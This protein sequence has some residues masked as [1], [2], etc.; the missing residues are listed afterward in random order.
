[1]KVKI[2]IGNGIPTNLR[3][4]TTVWYVKEFYL[5][6]APDSPLDQANR[7]KLNQITL[8]ELAW[9]DF[10]SVMELYDLFYGKAGIFQVN[11]KPV[12]IAVGQ[13]FCS[14]ITLAHS[15][16]IQETV[17]KKVQG[18]YTGEPAKTYFLGL[19]WLRYWFDWA[20]ENTRCPAICKVKIH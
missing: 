2:T 20:I 4:L 8:D 19:L 12:P 1:M 6:T 10:L 11:K 3:D 5:R 17:T 13:G 7:F 18:K 9:V 15:R 16:V 14:P